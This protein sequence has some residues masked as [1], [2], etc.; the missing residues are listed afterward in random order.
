VRESE[1]REIE[2][3]FEKSMEDGVG[4][5]FFPLLV[6]LQKPEKKTPISE[7]HYCLK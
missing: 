1:R 3:H 6:L 5:F 4:L 2:I 7:F